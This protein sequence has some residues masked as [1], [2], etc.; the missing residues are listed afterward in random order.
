M[1]SCNYFTIRIIQSHKES[2]KVIILFSHDD[3]HV[4]SVWILWQEASLLNS[5]DLQHHPEKSGSAE[6][7]SMK[8]SGFSMF[9]EDSG[10]AGITR[11][12]V[13]LEFMQ[14][15]KKPPSLVEAGGLKEDRR[16][17]TLPRSWAQYHRRG[18]P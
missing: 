1:P 6:T 5:L 10:S 4:I 18:G 9:P 8:S 17:A 15:Q 16:R 13:I 7:I 14:K 2:H 3:F 12:S 11:K